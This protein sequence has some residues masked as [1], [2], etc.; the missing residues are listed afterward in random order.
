MSTVETHPALLRAAAERSP[1][2]VFLH[3]TSAAGAAVAVTF[4]ELEQSSRRIASGLLRR[5]IGHGDR[6][7]VAAPNCVE[8]LELFF[9]AT[10]IGAIVVTLNV[11]YREAE[12][13]YMLTQSGARMVVTSPAADGF[14]LAS[15]YS[16]FRPQI[17]AVEEVVLLDGSD[18]GFDSLR[19]E[20]DDDELARH[21][22]MVRPDDPA[23]ILYTSGTTGRPKGAVLTH[24]SM[25]ASARGQIERLGTTPDDVYL[26]VMPLNHVGGITCSV[27][28]AL[29]QGA[30]LVLPQAF[31]PAATLADI[32]RHRV[33]LFAGVPTMWSLMLAHPTFAQ[34]DTSSVRS[35]VV[36]GSTLDPTLAEQ[37]QASFPGARLA[38]LYG[39][40]ESS[41]AAIISPPGDTLDQVAH[42]LGTALPGVES[43]VV[44]PDGEPLPTGQQG[45]LE[46]RGE[47]IAAGYWEQPAES[48][49]AFL[50]GGWLRTGD[51][52]TQE[53]DGRVLMHGR[54]K[55]MLVQ[56]GYNV[57][58]VEV[59]HLLTSH[60]AVTMAAGIGVPD[61]V[62]G[63][64]GCYYVVLRPDHDVSEDE[65]RDLCRGQLADY[66]VPRQVVVLDEL[67]TTPS[68]KIAKAALRERYDA[69]AGA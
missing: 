19:A 35:V 31:S 68:G 44:G 10:R 30:T 18:T 17:P 13:G 50:P 52:V 5:G 7:A 34:T 59:E 40:S 36:G 26:C 21:E 6:I 45:E 48:A 16:G 27:T 64:V 42:S 56:G 38:N 43:R 54:S 66:K 41:G 33:S 14:D 51:M 9:A 4:T 49:A 32:G 11:R 46:L 3:A 39:L 23:V 55:E 65:L 29:A 58:P 12:L 47:S 24:R 69:D 28:S 61:P 22:S 57:Y 1:S 63:E 62:L 8:W 67:P 20:P 15:F 60:P 37:V 25:V 53:D 2:T